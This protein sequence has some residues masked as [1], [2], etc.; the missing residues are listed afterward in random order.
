MRVRVGTP[1]L[2]A[3]AHSNPWRELGCSSSRNEA[4]TDNTSSPI[5]SDT[6]TTTP[7]SNRDI[8]RVF[9]AHADVSFSNLAR[10]AFKASRGRSRHRIVIALL[11]S[12]LLVV[13]AFLTFNN[14]ST[15]S[16]FLLGACGLVTVFELIDL[17]R[18]HHHVTLVKLGD[19]EGQAIR[20]GKGWLNDLQFAL[21]SQAV[22][23]HV[24]DATNL[25]RLLHHV[26]QEVERTKSSLAN[27]PLI[28]ALIATVLAVLSGLAG[29]DDIPLLVWFW[30]LILIG[31]ILLF[32]W[33]T[34]E[35]LMSQHNRVQQLLRFVERL[36][37]SDEV[38]QTPD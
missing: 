17:I 21:F 15:L 35:L 27:H 13:G 37:L 6:A 38:Q 20:T 3:P 10:V 11:V 16:M 14:S 2:V 34:P 24:R 19:L 7:L 9:K 32:L 36:E 12:L 5:P 8:R 30:L 1:M 29:R 23:T 18:R 26:S 28:L 33:Q 25:D 22:P 4:V 31:F